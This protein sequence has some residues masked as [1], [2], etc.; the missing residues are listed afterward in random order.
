MV[1]KEQTVFLRRQGTIADPGI[2][3]GNLHFLED[4]D[5]GAT[6]RG[7]D[8]R[9]ETCYSAADNDDIPAFIPAAGGIVR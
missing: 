3:A 9:C 5:P 6:A 1:T 2:A 7:F 4:A 8:C